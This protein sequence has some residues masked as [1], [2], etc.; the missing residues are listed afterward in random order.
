MGVLQCNKSSI[1]TFL[2]LPIDEKYITYQTPTQ[3]NRNICAGIWTV[4][5][6]R[7]GR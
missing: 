2:V 1:L 6:R 5:G 3:G 4:R 7:H